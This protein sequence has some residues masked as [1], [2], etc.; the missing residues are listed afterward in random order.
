MKS[1]PAYSTAETIAKNTVFLTIGELGTRVFSFL[2]VIAIA[3]YLADAGLGAFAF[4][5]AFTDILLNFIDLGVP[6]YIAR[7][8]AKN[9]ASSGMYVS[10]ALGLRLLMVPAIPLI[11]IAMWLVAA[12]V[13]HATTPQTMLI[14]AL[15][16]LGMIF[17]FLNDPFRMVFM[18]HERDEYYSGL[19][20]FERLM[21]TV[22]GFALLATG[23]G[24]VAI[25]TAF[26]VSQ[27]ISLLT[28]AYFVRKKFTRFTI[29]LDRKL[30]TSIVKN[31][32]WFGAA[33]FLR[34]AAQRIDIV[35]LSVMQGF[36]VTG[37]YAAASRITESLR[38]I[39]LVVVPAIFPALSRLNVQSRESAKLLFEKTFYYMLVAAIPLAVGV[40][41]T[42]DRIIPFLYNRPEFQHSILALKLLVWAEALLFLHYIMGFLLN[43]INKQHLFT[44]AT[45]AYTVMNVLLNLIMI[46]KYSY[47]GA[48]TAAL[49]TQALA[50]MTL[51]Y[52][53]TKNGY[54]LNILRLAYKPA[55][56]AAFMALS[57]AWLKGVHLLIAAPT[58]A[59]AY[60]AVLILIRGIGK[61]ELQLARKAV[62]MKRN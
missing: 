22:S 56:A 25:L 51:Y 24:L 23:F 15:A 44:I 39:P 3:R 20:I 57:L 27:L 8:M 30:I 54:G 45:L 52:F 42:A 59:L 16:L 61:E 50:A 34:M 36:A 18:A 21:F 4:A 53:C 19:I 41:L 55:V 13:I 46:P 58:A 38:F 33:N 48:A 43:A 2:L 5:F 49:I 32:A 26:A 12:F 60:L 10:N 31:S 28:T 9:K 37:W 1:M 14:T 17:N 11:A 7:E 62:G 6:M 47:A 29:G 40:T 35:L